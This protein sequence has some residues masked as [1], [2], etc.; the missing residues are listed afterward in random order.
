MM[1][2]SRK[3]EGC[4]SMEQRG[5]ELERPTIQ[6]QIQ[7]GTLGLPHLGRLHWLLES[8]PLDS[9]PFSFLLHNFGQE[10]SPH[11]SSCVYANE[12]TGV[13]EPQGKTNALLRMRIPKSNTAGTAWCL[14]SL[15]SCSKR[16]SEK[17]ALGNVLLRMYFG[18][19]AWHTFRPSWNP[20][21]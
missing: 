14:G 11:L 20:F 2:Y 3:F 9:Q 1:W 13:Q 18:H 21:F 7:H 6:C 15:L 16:T 10:G 17:K 19:E 8:C 12:T 5:W 4:R